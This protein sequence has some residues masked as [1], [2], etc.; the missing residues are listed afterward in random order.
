LRLLLEYNKEDVV[1]LIA[2]KKKLGTLQGGP[3]TG[4]PSE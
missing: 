3:E 1:N 4:R 2:L